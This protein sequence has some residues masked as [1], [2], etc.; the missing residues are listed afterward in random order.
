MKKVKAYTLMEMLIVMSIIVIVLAIGISAYAAYIETTKYN[1]DVSNI[2]HD[3]LTMQKASMLF[4][5]DANDGW[6]YGMGIDFEGLTAGTRDGT[7]KFFKWCSGFTSFG[8]PRTTGRYPNYNTSTELSDGLAKV[9]NTYPSANYSLNSCPDTTDPN[10]GG[11][12]VN[13][14]TYG[15][16]S[17]N[18]G[19][20]VEITGGRYLLFESVTGR[21]FIFSNDGT[22]ITDP[23]ATLSITFY[24]RRGT[25]NILTIENLTGRTKL[26]VAP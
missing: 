9:S 2:E 26:S 1:Q 4:K 6:I 15:F 5:K 8:D 17:L 20:D 25:T 14:A 11:L 16:G 3:V 24:K 19:E 21:A 22:L 7:Y 23:T 13:L 18:L 10:E 12:L